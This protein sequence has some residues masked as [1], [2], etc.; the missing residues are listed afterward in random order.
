MAG[1][2]VQDWMDGVVLLVDLF[3]TLAALAFSTS[4]TKKLLLH[5]QL[6]CLNTITY[7]HTLSS[8]LFLLFSHDSMQKPLAEKLTPLRDS[9][10]FKRTGAGISGRCLC[11]FRSG[12]AAHNRAKTKTLKETR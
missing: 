12:K 6:P 2:T 8:P 11:A 1:G 3:C 4:S 5:K 9:G 7:L 10:A